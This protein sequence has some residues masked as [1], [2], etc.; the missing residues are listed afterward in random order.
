MLTEDT[1]NA[2]YK[3]HA[4]NENEIII[5]KIAYHDSLIISSDQL[6]KH[7]HPHSTESIQPDDL[8]AFIELSPD[9]ILLGTGKKSVILPPTVLAPLLEKNY[10]VECMSTA[11]ACRTYMALS[12]EGRKV[13]AGLIIENNR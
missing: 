1:S 5:N 10:N 8:L 11:A 6:I 4:Y 13:A 3:I 9:I 7:W 12:T 2:Q